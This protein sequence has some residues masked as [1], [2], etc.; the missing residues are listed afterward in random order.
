MF[1]A[2]QRSDGWKAWIVTHLRTGR[3]KRRFADSSCNAI[4][5]AGWESWE[6]VAQEVLPGT[7]VD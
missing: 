6:C 5:G 2:A 7:A 3:Q 1:N 4:L